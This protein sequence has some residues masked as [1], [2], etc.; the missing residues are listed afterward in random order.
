MR[1]LTLAL[2]LVLCLSVI[3]SLSAAAQS[4]G[5]YFSINYQPVSLSQ[6]EVQR[7]D[8]FYAT[9]SGDATCTKDVPGQSI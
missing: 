5:E 7:I 6:D 4:L 1:H 2:I 9:V 8:A 3:N